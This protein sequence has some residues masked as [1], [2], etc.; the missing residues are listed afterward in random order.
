[1]SKKICNKC[2]KKLPESDFYFN[3]KKNYFEYACKFCWN[4]RCLVWQKKVGDNPTVE[5]WN[6]AS[7]KSYKLHPEKWRARAKIRYAVKVGKIKKQS[8]EKCGEKKVQAHHTDY[9]KPLEVNWLCH[10]HHRQIHFPRYY[11][12]DPLTTKIIGLDSSPK[13]NF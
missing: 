9:S 5:D 11:K 4:N 1:M 3:K 12:N 10:I 6:K 13:G 7:K 8:C 2:R